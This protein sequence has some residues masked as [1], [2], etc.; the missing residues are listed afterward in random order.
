V[1]GVD[2]VGAVLGMDGVDVEDGRK[3]AR[4]LNGKMKHGKEQKGGK[5]WIMRKKEQQR[6]KGKIVKTD[7]KFTGRKRRAQF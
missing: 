2:L 6:N 1:G 3:I 5:K 4:E 7:S